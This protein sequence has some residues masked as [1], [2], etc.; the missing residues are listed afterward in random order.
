M[1]HLRRSTRP[2]LL[3]AI[4]LLAAS[5]PAASQP[6]ASQPAASQPAASQPA[7]TAAGPEGRLHVL[8]VT[9]INGRFA[10]PGCASR[11]PKRADLA[12]LIAAVKAKRKQI[13][14]AGDGEPLVLASG[15][16]LRP[17]ILGVHVFSRPPLADTAVS[18]LG[19]VGFDAVAVGPFDFGA[20]TAALER[21]MSRMRRA[22]IP[23]LSS[24]VSCGDKSA[25]QCRHLGALDGKPYVVLERGGVRVG[26][27]AVT[28]RDTMERIIKQ[29]A[30]TMAA[31]EP[32]EAA[33]ALVRKLRTEEKAQVVIL[34]ATLNL[35][36]ETPAP[37]VDFI[38]RLG[39]DAPDL[40]VSDSMFDRGSKDFIARIQSR[41][42]A[43]V[44]GTGRFGQHLGHA[45]IRY[46][47]ARDGKVSVPLIDVRVEP[48]DGVAPEPTALPKT[49]RLLGD[50]CRSV[51]VPL[52]QA[53]LPKPMGH[54]DFASYLLEIMRNEEGA[55]VALLNHSALAPTRLAAGPLTREMI[56]RGIR[57]LTHLGS[58]WLSGTRLKALLAPHLAGIKRGLSWR[59]VTKRGKVWK[60]NNRRLVDGLHYRVATSAFV[61]SGGDGLI[62]LKAERFRS[63]GKALRHTV[64]D[65]FERGRQ[66]RLDGDPGVSL[67]ADFP[68]PW[69]KWLIYG[70]VTA[71]VYASDLSIDNGQGGD[72]YN[73]PLLTRDGVASLKL[74]LDV[75]FGASNHNHA[76]E[77]DVNLQY[78]RTWTRTWVE[79]EREVVPGLPPETVPEKTTQ[80]AESLD[81]IRFDLLY[82]LNTLRNRWGEGR[83]YVPQPYA[84]ATMISEFT[85]ESTYLVGDQEQTY[86]YLDLGGTVGVGVMPHPLLFV[87]AGFAF[88][89]ELLTPEEKLLD[90]K[91]V[92]TG[93]YLGYTLRRLRLLSSPRHPLQFESRLDFFLTNLGG[94]FRKEV[95]LASKL[96]F[97]LTP[98]L[99][100]TASHS[101]FLFDTANADSSTANDLA[102]GLELLFDHRHQTY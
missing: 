95:T 65:F 77:A 58:V 61:A 85:A 8:F 100:L 26:L 3:A 37:V 56:E 78:G 13:R 76:L 11:D 10:W 9:D 92:R 54:D 60:V 75:S 70:G 24:N 23:L 50:L 21:Y 34:L 73:Q 90:G 22:K 63:S 68:D 40:V 74:E 57:S 15:S 2:L 36:N 42:G 51:D 1:H 79:T 30:G 5:Q 89:G 59:G 66:A 72:R 44:V 96:F 33:R 81:R 48:I 52:G 32:V 62:A 64:R 97:A 17:D 93:I 99:H 47:R 25:F 6:A 4:C 86:R 94:A 82:R 28:R 31:A 45:V 71:G 43:A 29:R 67:A 12:N 101:L 39:D 102:F 38:R 87:K 84:E 18:L 49:R 55:E 14:A 27:G 7:A 88:G 35:E 46:R 69:K 98:Y 80:S 20:P 41:L 16:M 53:S 19:D 83:W 91:E